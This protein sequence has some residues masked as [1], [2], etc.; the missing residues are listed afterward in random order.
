MALVDYAS[1][2]EENVVDEDLPR[3]NRDNQ[4]NQDNR[5]DEK[6]VTTKTS[7]SNHLKRKRDVSSSSSELPPL[8]SKFHDLYASTV[9]N[10]SRDDPSLHGGRKRVTPHIEG[11]WPTHIYIEWYPSTT[12]FD[13]ISS[14]ISKV[15]SFKTHDIQTFLSN[16]L[17]VPLPLHVSLS[18][19]I[20][21][22]K[23][24]K[25]TFLTSFE[26]VIKSSGVRPFGMGFSGLTWVPNYEKTRWFL[27]LCVITSESNALN[28][29]LHVSNKVVEEFGQPPLYAN[30]RTRVNGQQVAKG[31]H[32]SQQGKPFR[33]KTQLKKD[34]FHDMADVSDAFHISIAWTLLPPDQEL[35]EATERLTANELLKV[36][37]IQIKTEE[38]KAKIGNVVTNVPLPV[39]ITEGRSLFG[40]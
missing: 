28:K 36:K 27:V 4:I 24:V 22:S 5:Q 35:I 40:L 26:Q 13:L 18:R 20:G 6:N 39:G 14:L 30:S 1:S 11:N 8:P 12:E 19:S 38:I 37:Q 16:D 34:I 23:D 3:D 32:H 7:S 17:G 21:F 25:D 10:S 2:D 31:A 9:R 15:E 29:L 33:G